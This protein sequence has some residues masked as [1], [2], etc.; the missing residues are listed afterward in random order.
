R[1]SP[2]YGLSLSLPRNASIM[3]E[4]Y[5][6]RDPLGGASVN[7]LPG[8]ARLRAFPFPAPECKHSRQGKGKPCLLRKQGFDW[9]G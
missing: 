6:A 2:G 5:A 7:A 1:A 4:D 3:E 9:S 8:F